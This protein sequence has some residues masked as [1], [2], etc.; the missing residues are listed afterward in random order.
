[1]GILASAADERVA[2]VQFKDDS[3][4]VRLMDGR[5]ISVPLAWF[6]RLLGASG[7]Q[8]EN[9]QVAGGGYGIHW[10]EI[11]EDLSTEG[12]LRGAPA[13][14]HTQRQPSA[15]S[16]A[17]AR[18]QVGALIDCIKNYPPSASIADDWP[19]V[20]RA[21]RILNFSWDNPDEIRRRLE[22]TDPRLV[23]LLLSLLLKES[24]KKTS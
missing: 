11:D 1:M 13:P 8:R 18:E 20:V 17:A 19:D 5:W 4:S 7:A 12:L 23:L 6:P 21:S 3:L 2:D 24:E 22:E 9:W 15:S 16:Y 10:P 14:G